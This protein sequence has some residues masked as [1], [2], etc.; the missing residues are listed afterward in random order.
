[1]K[2]VR[3]ISALTLVAFSGLAVAQTTQIAPTYS[4]P[5]WFWQLPTNAQAAEIVGFDISASHL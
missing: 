1:M 3:A 5:C 2:S 4:P